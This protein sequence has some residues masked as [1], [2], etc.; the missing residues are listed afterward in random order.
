MRS[1][2]GLRMIENIKVSVFTM[3]C[4]YCGLF[5]FFFFFVNVSFVL[6]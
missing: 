4:A 3:H 1:G 2:E 5:F 6:A